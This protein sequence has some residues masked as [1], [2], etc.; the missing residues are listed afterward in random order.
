MAGDKQ[1]SNDINGVASRRQGISELQSTKNEVSRMT[2]QRDDLRQKLDK[3]KD[4][5]DK[6]GLVM[7][8]DK[9]SSD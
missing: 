8:N 1:A 2:H 3:V 4:E 5:Q 6:L 7:G 9:L